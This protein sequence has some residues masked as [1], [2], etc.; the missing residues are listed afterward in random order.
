MKKIA[1]VGG[2]LVGLV[3]CIV[4]IAFCVSYVVS[5]AASEA[6]HL[7]DAAAAQVGTFAAQVH[8]AYVKGSK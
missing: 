2:A 8:E 3:A 4:C 7:A 1:S 5:R 6:P